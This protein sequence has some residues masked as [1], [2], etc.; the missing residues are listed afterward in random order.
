MTA[1]KRE[2]DK[3]TPLGTFPLRQVWQRPDRALCPSTGLKKRILTPRHIWCDD[4]K[5]PLYNRWST[6]PQQA[7]H[8]KLWRHDHL[9]DI[10]IEIGYNDFPV[11]PY[12]GSAI[13]LHIAEPHTRWTQGCIAI[14]HHDMQRLL[15]RLT[16]GSCITMKKR[17]PPL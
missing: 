13:F 8:E 15:P 6:T 11:R 7:R 14:A 5:S 1:N 10:F 9:Y 17:L 3:A 2:N 12:K 4:P 16:S